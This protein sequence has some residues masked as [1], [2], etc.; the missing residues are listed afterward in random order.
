MYNIKNFIIYLYYLKMNKR[1]THHQPHIDWLNYSLLE[2]KWE[3]DLYRLTWRDTTTWQLINILWSAQEI[4]DKTG[5]KISSPEIV[6][7]SLEW[8]VNRCADT[9]ESVFL[10]LK[11]K[12]PFNENIN[13]YGDDEWWNAIT[14][15]VDGQGID[16]QK[17][18]D[19]N[20]KEAL[21]KKWLKFGRPSYSYFTEKSKAWWVWFS[22]SF[23]N[24]DIIKQWEIERRTKVCADTL[25]SVFLRLK[26][27]DPFNEDI[28]VYADDEWWNAI[29]SLV[30]GA[31]WFVKELFD[32]YLKNE[33]TKKWLWFSTPSYDYFIEKSKAWTVWFNV[34]KLPI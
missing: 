15:L 28:N 11:E 26:E 21:E 25:E 1:Q 20:L 4:E 24:D 32:V 8:R 5:Y 33:L 30:D 13:V 2:Q 31:W 16:A 3:Q 17:L 6:D 19:I 23:L 12:D 29:T 14:S 9:L 27:K 34:K 7:N 22:I 10:R 18:F